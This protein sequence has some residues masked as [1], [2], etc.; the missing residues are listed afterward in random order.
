MRTI[1]G[2]DG[3]AL[4]VGDHWVGAVGGVLADDLVAHDRAAVAHADLAWLWFPYVPVRKH[5][6]VYGAATVHA[7]RGRH[8]RTL[9]RGGR[10]INHRERSIKA[11]CGGVNTHMRHKTRWIAA[12]H[13]KSV[14]STPEAVFKSVDNPSFMTR[15]RLALSS[16]LIFI[17]GQNSQAH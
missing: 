7:C 6:A 1:I 12:S 2:A 11:P 15:L 10:H 14:F 17:S 4:V 16:T 13:G 8:T 3:A 5:L 9:R